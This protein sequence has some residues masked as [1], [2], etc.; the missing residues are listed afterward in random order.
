[1][2]SLIE[3]RWQ[4]MNTAQRQHWLLIAGV[5]WDEARINYSC[6]DWQQLPEEL[7]DKLIE[8]FEG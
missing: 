6:L 4:D 8:T 5:P 3:T 2:A 7:G 1:M